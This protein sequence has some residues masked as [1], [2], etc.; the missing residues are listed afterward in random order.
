TKD[1]IIE[2]DERLALTVAAAGYTVAD[3]AMIIDDVTRRTAANTAITYTLPATGV[4]EGTTPAINFNLPAGVTTEIPIKI[5]LPSNVATE[6]ATRGTDYVL[7]ASFTF[8]SGGT[9]SATLDVKADNLVEDVEKISITPSASDDYGTAT[10]A[11]TP[12]LFD[13]NIND[14]QYPFPAGDSVL[15]TSVPDTVLEGNNVQITA[16]F[17]HGWIAGKD[18]TITLAKDAVKSTAADSRHGTVPAS[19][20]ITKASNSGTATSTAF[21]TTTNNVF[22]DDAILAINGNVGNTNMPAKTASVYI[23][24]NT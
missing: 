2:K 13:L 3:T 21:N 5:S 18:W 23:K 6:T 24:D 11:F 14:A 10:Y 19:I 7:P 20:T 1:K 16:T 22:D 4:N 8:S 15:L 12:A 9:G 17:P